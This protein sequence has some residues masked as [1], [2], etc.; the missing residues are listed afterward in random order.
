ML[1]DENGLVTDVTVLESN[2][3]GYFEEAAKKAFLHA[4]F[5]PGMKDGQPVKTVLNIQ[6][7]FSN[8]MSP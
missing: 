7:Q 4:K 1:L 3:P 6:V 5:T 8:D 2:P